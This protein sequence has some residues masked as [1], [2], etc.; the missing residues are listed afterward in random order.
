MR[1]RL[2]LV[3]SVFSLL[4]VAGFA[5]PLL[6]I[7]SA[8]RTQRFTLVR[9]ADLDRFA[10][11]AQ[12]AIGPLGTATERDVLAREVRSHVA[13]YGEGVVVVDGGGDPVVAAGLDA[14]DPAVAAAVDAALRNQPAAAPE[15]IG[16]LSTDP[17]LLSRPVGI[18][19][20]VG[21][22][23]GGRGGPSPG[24]PGGGAGG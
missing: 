8:E 16:P 12:Q 19:T 7:T 9:T 14:A 13:L 6:D 15:R 23:G 2:L 11:L 1:R 20:E 22:A 10:A 17:V 18:G 5:P 24:G 4:A 21:G 3:L